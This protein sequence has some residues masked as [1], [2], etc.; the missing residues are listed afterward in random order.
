MIEFSKNHSFKWI[1]I[2]SNFSS[3]AAADNVEIIYSEEIKCQN[4]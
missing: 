1:C 4:W 2:F 3:M